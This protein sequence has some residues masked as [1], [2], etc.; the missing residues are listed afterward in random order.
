MLIVHPWESA[1][2]MPHYPSGL[3][4]LLHGAESFLFLWALGL[5]YVC[6]IQL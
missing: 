3:P 5:E 6:M 4:Q 2:V 1:D